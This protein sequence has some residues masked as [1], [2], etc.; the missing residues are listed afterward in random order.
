[1]KHVLLCLVSVMALMAASKETKVKLPSSRADLANGEK[2]FQNHCALCHGLNGG[3]GRGPML[4]QAKLS[5]APDDTALLKVI[6]EGIR[7]TEMPG[8]DSMSDQEMKQ[9][10]AYVRSLGR[11]PQKPV[12]G[13]PT[14][15]AEIYRGKGKC[16]TCHSMHGEGGIAGPDLAGIG[17]RRSAGYLRESLVD[18]G[19]AVPERYLLV[20][21]VAKDGRKVTGV[22]VNE[23]S[24]SL[25]IR[26]DSG[27]SYSFW[28]HEIAQA[29]KQRGKSP[30]PS[31][32]GQLSDDELTDL[33]AYLASLKE[34]K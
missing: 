14:L 34:E 16:A 5:R 4:T 12:P 11:V 26:D 27:R 2:L 10:A 15:G 20:T 21:V 6:E 24:F 7:G 33:V 29:D 13:N 18:P 8:A 31:Y 23:D 1:M 22:R 19:A 30:M 32:K 17:G 28:K 3:G 9:T 25:Q